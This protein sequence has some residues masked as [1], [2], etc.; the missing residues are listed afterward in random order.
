MGT[1]L[2]YIRSTVHPQ[3]ASPMH[4]LWMMY[5]WMWGWMCCVVEVCKLTHDAPEGTET[6]NIKRHPHSHDDSIIR[7]PLK[8]SGVAT[9]INTFTHSN[10]VWRFCGFAGKS[11]TRRRLSYCLV[12]YICVACAKSQATLWFACDHSVDHTVNQWQWL[13]LSTWPLIVVSSTVTFDRSCTW[14]THNP[15]SLLHWVLIC[16]IVPHVHKLQAHT[17]LCDDTRQK[18]TKVLISSRLQNILTSLCEGSLTDIN[19][20]KYCKNNCLS[21]LTRQFPS[22]RSDD[23]PNWSEWV[24]HWLL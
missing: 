9:G 17:V 10:K 23:L 16:F 12:V 3:H 2:S 11:T 24:I 20:N 14:F 5:R 13:S 6:G 18:I 1:D 4:G 19:R 7:I 22:A 21:D 15:S 8:E